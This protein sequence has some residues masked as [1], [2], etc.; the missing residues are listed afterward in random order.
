[1]QAAG[2]IASKI[3]ELVLINPASSLVRLPW[4]ASGS[5]L[6]RVLPDALYPLSARI[7]VN[8]L[9]DADRVTAADR[10]CL[11]DAMLSVQPQSAAWRLDL[12]RQFNVHSI[13]PKLV[14]IPVSL[15]A[16]ELD[17]LLPSVPE[18]LILEQLLPKSK[19]KFL[20]HSGH[21]CLLEKDIYLAD[22]L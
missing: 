9:I 14:D 3:S 5:A 17:R 6:T 8:F 19:T 2:K 15:I 11:L 16:G 13:L 20:P 4:L 21:A 10:Q 18:V 12:L 22:L 7:L 1:M